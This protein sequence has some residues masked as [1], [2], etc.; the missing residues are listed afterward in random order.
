MTN[1]QFTAALSAKSAQ[2]HVGL[3]NSTRVAFE[4]GAMWAK[5]VL[6]QEQPEQPRPFKIGDRVY[7]K[8]EDA[9][10]VIKEIRADY[11]HAL[12]VR[13]RGGARSYTLDGF[14]AYSGD[15]EPTLFH[16]YT[17]QP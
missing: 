5:E 12:L 16:T 11:S 13:F 14:R 1:E 2:L 4:A 3:D 8:H 17:T 10:G 7:C 15:L 6:Q 9:T